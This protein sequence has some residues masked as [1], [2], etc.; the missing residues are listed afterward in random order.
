MR[1]INERPNGSKWLVALFGVVL[2]ATLF[3]ESTEGSRTSPTTN[4]LT[5]SQPV[6]LPGVVLPQGTYVFEALVLEG[7]LVRVSDCRDGRVRYVGFTRVI[8]R[9]REMAADRAIALGE[10]LAGTA[11]LVQPGTPLGAEM[12]RSFCTGSKPA[13]GAGMTRA[14]ELSGDSGLERGFHFCGANPSGSRHLYEARNLDHLGKRET[15]EGALWQG[16]GVDSEAV[17][18][19]HDQLSSV[20]THQRATDGFSRT[21]DHF[22]QFLMRRLRLDDNVLALLHAAL[23]GQPG[24]APCD[25]ILHFECVDRP[26]LIVGLS[27][28]RVRC[29]T[30]LSEN[31]WFLRRALKAG[32][33]I[34]M[35]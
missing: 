28:L 4:L 26:Q 9:P 24:E 19:P 35:N 20:E 11:P 1:K 3:V 5:F 34:R 22:C 32:A 2:A 18:V 17:S 8:P 21:T 29:D 15:A 6:A 31:A 33:G 12:I 30:S 10:A 25:S 14:V 27:D 16:G 7:N 13:G 23:L